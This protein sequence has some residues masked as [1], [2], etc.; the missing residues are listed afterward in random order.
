MS[1]ESIKDFLDK[2]AETN[3][4]IANHYER[5]AMLNLAFAR[6][7]ELKSSDQDRMYFI[8][9]LHE[10][11]KY[12]NEEFENIYPKI[13]SIIL[14]THKGFS[15]IAKIVEQC[16][17]NIDGS[18]FPNHLTKDDIH[19]FAIACH[20]CD[21]YDHFRM[22]G[23]DHDESIAKLRKL[24]DIIGPKKL[25]TLFVKMMFANKELKELYEEEDNG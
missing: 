7:L 25:V 5:V 20:I 1:I 14:K 10:I 8:G 4:E 12:N 9:L 18:G 13:S 3:N 16:E 19:L 22:E 23:Y 21:K 2:I 11:G 6:E 17:E 15:K 24:N